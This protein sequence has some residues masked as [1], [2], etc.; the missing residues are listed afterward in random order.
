MQFQ[1][2]S[3][4]DHIPIPN[5]SSNSRLWKIIKSAFGR[6]RECSD[7]ARVVAAATDSC[8]PGCERRDCRQFGALHRTTHIVPLKEQVFSDAWCQ[9]TL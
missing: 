8:I 1:A 9:H 3:L 7:T 2:L 5:T 6:W 4:I